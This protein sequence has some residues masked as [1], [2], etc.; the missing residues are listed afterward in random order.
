MINYTKNDDKK[1]F[2]GIIFNNIAKRTEKPAPISS[3]NVSVNA[4]PEIRVYCLLKVA[5]TFNKTL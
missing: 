4:I 5:K 1:T 3:C 2:T